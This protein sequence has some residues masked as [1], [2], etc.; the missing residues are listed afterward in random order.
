MVNN[1]SA[2]EDTHCHNYSIQLAV[3]VPFCTSSHW[4]DRTHHG[5]VTQVVEHQLEWEI[6]HE[7]L[8]RWPIADV[9]PCDGTRSILNIC[10]FLHDHKINANKVIN[11][12]LCT[13][14]ILA[15][16]SHSTKMWRTVAHYTQ[17]YNDN[18]NMLRVS[19]NIVLT[20]IQ[21]HWHHTTII[22][23]W[24]MHC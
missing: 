13:F 11:V 19:L 16:R 24:L 10:F 1:H 23:I 12:I 9:L 8:I 18:N 5:F 22:Y 14:L 3:R 7:G 17:K 6:A 15:I 20:A 2:R 4:Q 21:I